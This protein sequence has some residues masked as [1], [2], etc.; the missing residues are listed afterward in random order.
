M[1]EPVTDG[2]IRGFRFHQAGID[3]NL[4]DNGINVVATGHA[5]NG[6]FAERI[7]VQ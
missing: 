4:E 1:A 6:R 5:A 3:G 7:P 2:L